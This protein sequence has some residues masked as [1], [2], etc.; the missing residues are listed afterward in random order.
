MTDAAHTV[1]ETVPRVVH[2]VVSLDHGGLE[3]LVVDWTNARN[4]RHPGSTRVVCLVA[5]GDLAALVEG[6]AVYCAAAR[7][8][9]FPFDWLA[10]RRI[11]NELRALAA[12]EPQADG[13][14]FPVVV[15]SHNMAPHQYAVLATWGSGIPHVHTQHG[16]NLHVQS[17]KDR[18]RSRV[19][20][21]LTQRLIAV[22][23]DTAEVMAS[24]QGIPRQR[25]TIVPNGVSAHP[26]YGAP[27]LERLQREARVP[28][29]AFVLGS[30]GRLAP[31]KGYDRL[32]TAFAE[33][34][35][36]AGDLNWALLLVG[37]GPDRA[38]LEASARALGIA[39]R[40]HFAGF[41]PDARQ[42]LE[43]MDMFVLPSRSEGLSIALL[44]AMAAGVP[45]A[46]TDV[47]ESRAVI[48]D[49]QAGFILADDPAQWPEC[50]LQWARQ[51][52]AQ[53]PAVLQRTEAAKQRVA[54][55][56]SM[57]STLERYE[58]LYHDVLGEAGTPARR[59]IAV[60]D[61]L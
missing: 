26:A 17:L 18:V 49:G 40:V 12:E 7:R 59:Q 43:L 47:G 54:S 22:S 38:A 60:A 39:D 53:D 19:L 56:Y 9:R 41:Q 1:S 8:N 6:R 10:V 34:C 28:A 61:A 32:I 48:G 3:R 25:L 4:R 5:P 23:R 15:H 37:D 11:R 44:E 33:L 14:P 16:P 46:V 57:E 45:A 58:R 35:R 27:Q 24:R 42:Y 31:V 55:G 29:A 30:V 13:R 21:R 20:C 36:R 2:V 50:L 51:I 52:T